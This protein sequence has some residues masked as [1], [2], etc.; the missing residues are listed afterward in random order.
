M[1]QRPCIQLYEGCLTV[2]SLIRCR[3][4]SESGPRLTREAFSCDEAVLVD[5]N[6]DILGGVLSMSLFA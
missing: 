5:H 4:K 1:L 6:I 2:F 3:Q